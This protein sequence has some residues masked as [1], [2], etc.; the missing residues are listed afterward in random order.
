MKIALIGGTHG[1]E[2]VGIE[3]MRL[4]ERSNQNYENTYQ[5]FLGNPK[6]LELGKRY[7]D[8][9]LNRCVGSTGIRK[10]YEKE[11]VHELQS[12]ISG[13]FDFAIDLHTTT[14]NMGLTVVL[15]NTHE[16]SQKAAVFLKSMFP[17]IKIIEEDRLDDD[18]PH[19][20][21]LCPSGVIIEVGPVANNVLKADLVLK[22]YWMVESLLNFDFSEGKPAEPTEI[23]KQY[24]TVGYPE[25]EGWYVHP[26]IEGRDFVEVSQ[27]HPCFIN[28]H[29][30]E[31]LL[32]EDEPCYPF[33]INEAAY[34]E[35]DCAFILARKVKVF[36]RVKS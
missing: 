23:Y 25:G 5:C 22:T 3:V 36:S 9:D 12:Q 7:V 19:I 15:T 35:K 24:K 28:I 10:G 20:N 32:E 4:F 16:N 1:N 33:F 34:L 8:S 11:R 14:S 2:P 31:I 6:A 13:S 18:S 29:G 30:D 21:R 27:G 26:E 17:E